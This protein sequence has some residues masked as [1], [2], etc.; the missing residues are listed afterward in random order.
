VDRV[1]A[2][3]KRKDRF[4]F[5]DAIKASE[6]TR[7]KR[8][9]EMTT[10]MTQSNNAYSERDRRKMD[11]VQLKAAEKSDVRA[12]Q[13]KLD[14][15]NETIE[16]QK[17]AANHQAIQ[18]PDPASE[19]SFMAQQVDQ[20][21]LV[22]LTAEYETTTQ[23]TL[24]LTK[25]ADINALFAEAEKLE[26]ENFSLYS[27]V[28][29]HGATRSRLQEDIDGL[30]LQRDALLAQTQSTEEE[31]SI[32]L[33]HLTEEIQKVDGELNAIRT[34]KSTNETQFQAVYQE[35]E[36]IFNCLNCSWEQAPD[37]KATTTPANALFCLS[38]VE[39]IIAD[40]ANRVYEATKTQYCMGKSVA[41]P[42]EPQTQE[43]ATI[44]KHP[45]VGSK[46]TIAPEKEVPGKV[47][48]SNR[49]LSIEEM[50]EFLEQQGA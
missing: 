27:Y 46:I 21:E 32:V 19:L 29:D 15:L 37:G 26:R 50:I 22:T 30:E 42:A 33:E 35:I 36:A 3:P 24:A 23:A 31:Q 43:P 48:E 41:L 17:A 18:E 14:V 47:P 28:V 13:D 7:Q 9:G 11:L 5:R 45:T 49:P 8:D 6:Q 20:D 25:M 34:E 1:T 39:S 12:F 4:N 10:L 40:F 16:N 44:T 2:P 38:T